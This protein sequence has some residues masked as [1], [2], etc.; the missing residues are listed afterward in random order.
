M[1]V[2]RWNFAKEL[3]VLCLCAHFPWGILR[4]KFQC[5]LLNKQIWFLFHCK[6]VTSCRE[7]PG[8]AYGSK[9]L[10]T[11]NVGRRHLCPALWCS[12]TSLS[13]ERNGRKAHTEH[14]SNLPWATL[15]ITV[16]KLFT[17]LSLNNHLCLFDVVLYLF[18][19]VLAFF[20][21]LL[22]LL[23]D[24][25]ISTGWKNVKK[26]CGHEFCFPN[27]VFSLSSQDNTGPFLYQPREL[28]SSSKSWSNCGPGDGG[29][30]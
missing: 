30:V 28:L 9:L 6:T 10:A 8:Q 20:S 15:S 27:D 17:S 3:G 29:A 12:G 21:C 1:C 16:F 11:K 4:F 14:F 23:M 19:Q 13:V 26:D 18:Y 25:E 24:Y 22:R 5:L 7:G 2:P